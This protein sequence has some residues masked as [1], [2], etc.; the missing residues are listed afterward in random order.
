MHRTE[1]EFSRTS[2]NYG[3]PRLRKNRSCIKAWGDKGRGKIKLKSIHEEESI[4]GLSLFSVFW[5]F[6]WSIPNVLTQFGIYF[7]GPREMR[8]S[9]PFARWF[10]QCLSHDS[11]GSHNLQ[12]GNRDVINLKRLWKRFC[13]PKQV[14]NLFPCSL[15]RPAVKPLRDECVYG[16]REHK[17]ESRSS[18]ISVKFSP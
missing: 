10:P 3:W 16:L 11:L 9:W 5:R 15:S 12:G 17:R 14:A 13:L 4:S 8:S 1:T 6:L 2:I 7:Q 18:W